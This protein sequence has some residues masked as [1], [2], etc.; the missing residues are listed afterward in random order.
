MQ[1]RQG[2]RPESNA[3]MQGP[4]WWAQKHMALKEYEICSHFDVPRAR[5]WSYQ[6][7]WYTHNDFSNRIKF[8]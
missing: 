7:K 8:S 2:H 1:G 4:Q 6:Q 3:E 5:N